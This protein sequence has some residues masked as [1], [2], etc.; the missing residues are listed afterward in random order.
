VPD[1][2]LPVLVLIAQVFLIGLL[3]GVTALLLE[4]TDERG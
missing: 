2:L 3:S 1:I 4:W